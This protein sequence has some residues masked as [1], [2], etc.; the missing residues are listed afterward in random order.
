MSETLFEVISKKR[1]LDKKIGELKSL[2]QKEQNDTIVQE[3][4]ALLELK[5]AYMLH[6]EA[7]NNA[8]KISIG[9]TEVTIAVAVQIRRTIREKIEVITSLISNPDC[10]LNKIE[11]QQQ[12]DRYYEE[13]TLLTLGIT[14][15]DLKVTIG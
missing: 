10:N 13:Y 1:I 3:F 12:R 15:N 8:S 14:R 11:L 4:Y 6:I 9:G 5:Q 2:L 7:A